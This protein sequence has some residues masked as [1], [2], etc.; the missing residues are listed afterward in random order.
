MR[1]Y[2]IIHSQTEMLRIVSCY[3]YG[4]GN[5]RIFLS[6]PS[7]CAQMTEKVWTLLSISY[8]Q[9]IILAARTI[10]VETDGKREYDSSCE[11]NVLTADGAKLGTVIVRLLCTTH[12][13]VR[14]ITIIRTHVIIYVQL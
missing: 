6:K 8:I 14:T 13:Y 4:F 1:G 10:D 2:T 7:L 9:Y 3:A 11:C 12:F 5:R